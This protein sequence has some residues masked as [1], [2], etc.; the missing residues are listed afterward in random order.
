VRR[1]LVLVAI[2]SIALA[3][4]GGVL[5]TTGTAAAAGCAAGWTDAGNNVCERIVS[6]NG[7]PSGDPP[8]VDGTLQSV[9]V[10]AGVSSMQMVVSGA[11][12]G[13][14]ADPAEGAGRSAGGLGGRVTA[15]VGVTPGDTLTLVVGGSGASAPP[16]GWVLCGTCGATGPFGAGGLASSNNGGNGGGGSFVFDG[17]PTPD[18]G[19]GNPL[20]VAGG[21]GGGGYDY[22]T[23]ASHGAYGPQQ[24]PGGA[25]AGVGT[26][27]DGQSVAFLYDPT[28]PSV[29]H[30]A[31][32]GGG[33]ASPLAAGAGGHSLIP[34]SYAFGQVDGLPGAGPA[35]MPDPAHPENAALYLGA[36]GGS[37]KGT[38]CYYYGFGGGGGGGW[39]GGGGGGTI[40]ADLEGGGGG[41]GSGYAAP[42][43]S[44][45]VSQTGAQAGD[46][47]VILRYTVPVIAVP[48]APTTLGA[49]PGN[50]A[51]RVTWKAGPSGGGPIDS[52]RVSS[53]KAGVLQ[54]TTT[55]ASTATAQTIGGLLNGSSY[56]FKVAAHNVGGWGAVS[57]ASPAIV[58]G[59][60]TAPTAPGAVPGSTQVTVRWAAPTS[61]NGSAVTGYTVRTYAGTTLL[62]TSTLGVV[63]STIVTGLAN[64]TSYRFTI[65]ARNA[66]GTG[67]VSTANAV[68]GAPVAP[69]GVSATPGVAQA[70]VK[71][72]APASANGAPVTGY[73]VTP[74]RAGVAQAA[75]TFGTTATTQTI[76]GLTSG[77]SYT[78][79]V[80]AR[81]ARGLGPA[82]AASVAVV[83]G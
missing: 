19:V 39:Y 56:T 77:A 45:V 28:F 22:N 48:G 78:F 61:T 12:G 67:P 66:R 7:T 47:E 27:G 44:G 62:K 83:I 18:G 79:R 74:Y 52:F 60:P 13:D 11:Q 26:A 65:A 3:S 9:T 53:Y 80:A 17:R 64:G 41:G 36:G 59:A 72:T 50:A 8:V 10:P 31:P 20:V 75:R 40:D 21:G 58:V 46:G 15:T 57:V 37:Q 35:T 5:G 6:Y 24:A 51:A 71:W 69:T 16:G 29:T 73:V 30:Y 33:G 43:A 38:C 1:T 82:S 2:S 49:T 32:G 34:P 25:G 54:S 81:N 63:T 23:S 42:G 70:T 55:F 68:A 76:T 4:V 14:S